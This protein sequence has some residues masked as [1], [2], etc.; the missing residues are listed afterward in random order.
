VTELV[1]L[2]VRGRTAV[3]TLQRQ[4]KRNALTIELCDLIRE[5]A[6]TA[7]ADG[8]RSLVV[9]GE[10]TSFCSGADLDAVYGDAFRESLYGMLHAL[11][12]LPVPVVAAVNGPAI[13]AGTQLAIA[14]DVRVAAP[15]AAF[16]IP[17]AGNALAVDPWTIR[18]FALLAGNGAARAAL[19]GL[20]KIDADRAHALGLADRLGTVDDAIAWAEQ[21]AELAPLT[22]AYSKQVLNAVFE[23]EFEAATAAE[24]TRSFEACW[25]SDDFAEGRAARLEKRKPQFKGL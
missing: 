3:V 2:S 13:G 14:C 9:T 12:A 5:A 4:A 8:A 7:V 22:L 25:T 23:P 6:T 20:E 10:G 19:L 11:A 24:L 15:G 16:A 21:M 18:R 1:D 17:T